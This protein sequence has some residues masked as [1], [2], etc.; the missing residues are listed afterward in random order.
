M[1]RKDVQV[2]NIRIM[3]PSINPIEVQELANDI[4]THLQAAGASDKYVVIATPYGLQLEMSWAE[5]FLKKLEDI[6]A[7]TSDNNF[8]TSLSRMVAEARRKRWDKNQPEPGAPY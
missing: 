3:D 7:L 5:E 6:V 4:A 8:R 2:L 1:L